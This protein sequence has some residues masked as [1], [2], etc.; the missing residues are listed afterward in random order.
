MDVG[1]KSIINFSLN[2]KF[3]LWIMTII[4]LFG[5]VYAGTNMKM[6]TLPDITVPIVS[7]TTV[8]P[9]LRPRRS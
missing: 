5:G 1:L 6:E 2:N 9:G 8:Y 3:A 7:V 4:V